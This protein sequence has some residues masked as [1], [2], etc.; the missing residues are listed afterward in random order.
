MSK[1]IELGYVG[2]N[3]TDL[4]AWRTFST[5]CVGLEIEVGERD[6]CFY[7]ST[8]VLRYLRLIQM[9]WLI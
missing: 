4:D 1:V 6:D 9:T 7:I 2:L 5:E 8:T 3:V